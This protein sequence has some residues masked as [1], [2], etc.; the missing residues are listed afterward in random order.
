ME[1]TELNFELIDDFYGREG[2]VGVSSGDLYI[3]GVVFGYYVAATYPNQKSDLE[4]L[5]SVVDDN[6][7][8]VLSIGAK[9]SV[10]SID[11]LTPVDPHELPW[12]EDG[13]MHCEFVKP[14][15]YSN[16]SRAMQAFD[17][18]KFILSNDENINSY[19]RDE[20]A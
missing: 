4:L 3:D 15:E 13:V 16:Y 10:G 6:S 18:A 1:I 2:L 19:I 20:N 11:N 9:C 14:D 5:V 7:N 8:C 12:D 17:A